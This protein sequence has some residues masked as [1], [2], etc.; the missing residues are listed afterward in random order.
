MDKNIFPGNGNE[1]QKFPRLLTAKEKN[2]LFSILPENKP[3]YKIYREKVEEL[4]VIGYGRFREGNLILGQ[5]DDEPDNS[6][7]SSH[8]FAM[9]VVYFDEEG[10]NTVINEEADNKI[11]IDISPELKRGQ[12]QEKIMSYNYSE[13]NPGE[14]APG[15]K[16]FVREV[17]FLP[18][19]FLIAIAPVH[20]KIWVHDFDSMVNHIIPVSNLYSSLMLVK[21]I[22]DPD[23]ALK[24]NSLFTKLSVYSDEEISSAFVL[25]NK[26]FRRINFDYSYFQSQKT[27]EKKKSIFNIF[28]K[29]S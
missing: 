3:G 5:K 9:G 27:V 22:S 10:F 14:K 17:V 6:V 7:P 15:D 19:K 11:E 18:G 16:S 20:K 24:P 12:D 25:Y 1:T 23:I 13:W 4:F 2:L 26:N 29:G 8:I 28:K 21:G